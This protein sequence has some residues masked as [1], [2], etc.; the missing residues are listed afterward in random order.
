M[1]IMVVS[2]QPAR[3]PP[4]T[5]PFGTSSITRAEVPIQVSTMIDTIDL[6]D[7]GTVVNIYAN[8]IVEAVVAQYTAQSVVN[9][10]TTTN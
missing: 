10:S 6:H 4:T 9:V 8:I 2:F 7:A 5:A 1:K 3:I